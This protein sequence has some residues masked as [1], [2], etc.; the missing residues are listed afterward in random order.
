MTQ[1][2]L[3]ETERANA[4]ALIGGRGLTLRSVVVT[5]VSL[6]IMGAWIE[7]EEVFCRGGGPLAENSPAN[8]AVGVVL[9][10]LGISALLYRIRTFLRLASAELV[11]V[12]AAL[13][14]AAPLMTQGLWHRLFGLIAAVP[15]YADF[16][17]YESLPPMLWPHG[18]N[19]ADNGRFERQLDGFETAGEIGWDT[20]DW[21][22]RS[23]RVPVLANASPTN[24]PATL[25]F[26]V[27]AA[28]IVPGERFLF[29]MLV[30]ASAFAGDTTFG[31]S[32]QADDLPPVNLLT[33]AE[34]SRRSFALASGF[35]RIG[36]SPVTIPPAVSN[37]LTVAI[38]LRGEGMLAV[39]DLE[40]M[41]VEAVEGLYSGRQVVR[42]SG[43]AALGPHE[44]NF[45]LVRPDRLLSAAGVR[46]LLGGGIPLGQWIQPAAAWSLLIGA[47]F[48]GFLGLN[49]LMR[50]QW[51]EHERFTFPLTLLPK[52][53]LEE[54][55]GRLQ[56]FRNRVMWAGFAVGLPFVLWKG[57]AFYYPALPVP[58]QGARALA[59]YFNNPVLKAYFG[60][61]GEGLTGVGVSLSVFAV[62]LL[63]ETDVLF[64]LWVAFAAF[65]LWA[66]CGKAF[67]LSRFAGY[68][69]EHQQ[70]MGGY[71]AF[72]I[73]ALFVGRHH[74]ARVLRLVAGF[75]TKP[76]R[77]EAR[78][79]RGALALVAAS[80][81]AIAFWS[82]W[83]RM[84]V[85]AGLLF[86]GY[87][88]VCGFAASKIRAEMGAPW[89]YLTPYYGMQFVAALG[90]FAMFN[91]TGMLVATIAS[92]FMCTA[93]FLMIAP[94]QIEMMELGRHFRVHARD[95]GAGLTLGLLGGLFIGGFVLLCWAYGFGANNLNVSWPYEQNWY[96]N[97]F[98]AAALNADRALEAGTLGLVP[99][100]QTLNII[101]NPDAR[102]LAI[103]AAVTLI[104]AALRAFFTWFPLHPLGYVLASTFF[105]KG[106]WLYTL[107]AWA[108][109]LLLFRLG[110]ARTIRERLVPFCVGMFLA[111]IVSIVL[112][113]VVGLILRTRGITDVYGGLP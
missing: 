74:L 82:D 102:G 97:G 35:E 44:R 79:Y 48:A 73:M 106:L 13:I 88:L 62:A 84:G 109:R 3:P 101:H 36:V 37:Q 49:T 55:D 38:A 87:M 80:L 105:M 52:C 2:I 60:A 57:L 66:A 53:L 112:F 69:W 19:L 96:F 47:L 70:T 43:L 45:T 91:S 75:G 113:D 10:V 4:T 8:S 24:P 7:Y 98:R 63:V 39:H 11:V 77:H 95:V 40:F 6:L 81:A 51:V 78:T 92:G 28:A 67:N 23:W 25:V 30:K 85:S 68:P 65:Q 90:G 42:A 5:L 61:F 86:F 72:A 21:R 107:L 58:G 26:R 22:G 18:P 46:Y 29:S 33:R 93:C 54:K 9:L 108:V 76:E 59:D 100:S 64:S 104:L 16:K 17:S 83:T 31:V 32:L 89:P 94:A 41:N 15:H 27:P 12:Y 56:I 103:G 14:L 34:E 99:Q 71:I 111:G 1:R 110:G 50:K 20:I